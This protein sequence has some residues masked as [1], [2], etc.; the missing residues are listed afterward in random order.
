MQITIPVG[1]MRAGSLPP[2]SFMHLNDRVVRNV[3]DWRAGG[4]LL[5]GT[6]DSQVRPDVWELVWQ[7]IPAAT[8]NAIRAHFRDHGAG[9]W[10]WRQP[11]TGTEYVA[12]HLGPPIITWHNR[13]SSADVR[14]E[15]E[16]AIA[17]N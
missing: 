16:L 5:H 10:T 14:L 12:R 17:R 6:P 11:K 8:A 9:T 4:A 15:L 13:T 3:T 7:Q 1:S 2:P